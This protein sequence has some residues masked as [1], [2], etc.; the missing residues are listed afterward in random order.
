MTTDKA[1]ELTAQI[2]ASIEQLCKETD[3][4]KQSAM[5]RAWLSTM[6]RFYNYSFGNQ[7][8]IW[9]QCQTATRVA[10]FHAWKDLGRSVKKGEK[11]IRILAPIIRKYEEEKD[12][13]SV[14]TPRVVAFRCATV[15][16][17]VQT[18][19]KDLPDLE[20]NATEGR[21]DLL[22]ALE[23]AATVLGITFVYKSIPGGAEGLSRG[24]TIE[25]EETLDTHARCGVI[26]HELA[27]EVL[28]HKE[29]HAETT[30]QQRELEAES[31]A[32]AVLAHFGMRLESRFY[33]ATYDV[34]GEMLSASLATINATARQLIEA[35]GEP[36][37][38]TDEEAAVSVAA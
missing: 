20:C 7:I 14:K 5:Y 2:S 25:I 30:K 36:N 1:Q 34:T 27:H 32:F 10:G 23:K 26:V 3:A 16:D 21:E 35:I 24:G 37:R 15:F 13:Q 22:P 12:G 11:A 28:K 18:E 33:L 17:I 9:A 29:R 8:L 19:G 31:V 6:S 38:A 4:A